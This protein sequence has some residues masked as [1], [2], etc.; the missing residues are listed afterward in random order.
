MRASQ[1]NPCKIDLLVALCGAMIMLS[2]CESARN[3]LSDADDGMIILDSELCAHAEEV[4]NTYS[5]QIDGVLIFRMSDSASAEH[6]SIK[7]GL[8]EKNIKTRIA[9]ASKGYFTFLLNGDL[10]ETSLHIA[11]N[12]LSKKSNYGYF[13]KNKTKI[14]WKEIK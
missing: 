11:H 6:L 1:K 2:G 3:D 8:E 4:F 5:D 12:D 14:G 13:I 7:K 9:D 10:N